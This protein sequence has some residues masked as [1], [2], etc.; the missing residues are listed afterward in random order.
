MERCLGAFRNGSRGNPPVPRL[1][2]PVMRRLVALLLISI[3]ALACEPDAPTIG[4]SAAPS[5][6]P[7][8]AIEIWSRYPT[9][10]TELPAPP[11]RRDGDAWVWAGS[12]LL[13]AGG[14]DLPITDRC[15][16]TRRLLAFDP[17][18]GSWR[19]R[20]PSLAPMAD[21]DPVWTGEEAIFLETY[22]EAGPIHGQAYDPSS[23]DWRRIA[24]API[25][26]A[27][28]VVL[29]WTG[30]ELI[31]WGGG[32]RDDDRTKQGA[33][34]DP[35]S[36]SW[37]RIA[38]APIGLNLA[39]GAWTGREM[40][41][42]GSLLSRANRAPTPTA[43]GAA[44]DPATD[45]WRELPPSALSPQATSAV[46]L[47][48]QLVAWDYEVHSQVY[49]P[50]EDRWSA[51]LQM[52]LAF[53]E[54]YP[55]SEVVGGYL[56]AWFCG[57]AALYDQAIEDWQRIDDSGPLAETIYS[58]AYRREVEVW[59]F[60]DLVAAGPVVVMPMQGITL[61]NRGIA[62]YGCKGSPESFWVYRPPSKITPTRSAVEP[63]KGAVRRAVPELIFAWSVDAAG[64]LPWLVTESGLDRFEAHLPARWNGRTYRIGRVR[65]LGAGNFE[66]TVLL[67]LGKG[68]SQE[69]DLR[70]IT[71]VFGSGVSIG[72]EPLP[73]LLTDV[74]S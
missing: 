63:G 7:P 32:G 68:W 29:V 70:P 12:E 62:C 13:V 51:P 31:V 25:D 44:Y 33:A 47:G 50:G 45:T 15:P 8:Q 4:P 27:Y 6:S 10:W 16:E 23:A 19:I 38:D 3:V 36:D 48:D 43:V 65:D 42:F 64:L 67:D 22:G 2:F 18:V 46:L 26:R 41:V 37:R 59:R 57:H 52:P 54:C 61:S 35:I 28:G 74:R 1:V 60:A 69:A 72:G 20:P 56:L 9:G 24:R 34:Y 49:D 40:I 5:A 66:A 39:S 17:A 30:S 21:A 11:V 71:L 55:D 14:C 73:L 58:Q 53:S